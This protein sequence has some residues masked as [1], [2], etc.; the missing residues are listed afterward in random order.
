MRQVVSAHIM[1]TLSPGTGYLQWH[2]LDWLQ[3][4]TA[5]AARVC[6]DTDYVGL[7]QVQLQ[8]CIVVAM[9]VGFL[10]SSK[11]LRVPVDQASGICNSECHSAL[12]GKSSGVHGS[13]RAFGGV[14]SGKGC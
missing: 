6:T 8:G 1:T 2:W 3:K 11:L 13:H 9:P 14:L 10:H 4:G 7:S 12:S 5:Q